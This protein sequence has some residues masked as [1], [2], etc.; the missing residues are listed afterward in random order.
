MKGILMKS[1]K[2]QAIHESSPETEWQTRRIISKSNSF[3][4]VDGADWNKLCWDG[5]EVINAENRYLWDNGE[6][7]SIASEI[8]RNGYHAPLPY[9]DNSISPEYGY[10][11]TWHYLHVPYDWAESGTIYRVYPRFKIGEQ[12]YIK[13]SFCKVCYENDGIADVCF[14]EDMIT[15]CSKAVWKSPLFLPADL[16]RTVVEITDIR[17]Q[18]VQEITRDDIRAEGIILPVSPRFTPGTFSE[19]H[20]EFAF[21]WDSIHGEGAWERN[22]FIWAFGFKRIEEWT[23]GIK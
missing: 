15:P 22:D 7:G 9:V 6:R 11:Y 14:K 17:A 13:E 3:F 20:Q 12:V 5:S 8:A 2:A 1:W 21:L 16:A 10:D 19:L 4:G 18:R 23:G